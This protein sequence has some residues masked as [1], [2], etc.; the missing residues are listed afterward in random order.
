MTQITSKVISL[1]HDGRG[2]L[3]CGAKTAHVRFA[4]PGDEIEATLV[5]RVKG[6]LQGRLDRIVTPAPER[7][8]CEC[9]YG[10]S[11]GGCPLQML[12]YESQ[13]KWK[14]TFVEQAFRAAGFDFAIPEAQASDALFRHRNRMDYVISPGEDGGIALGLKEPGRWWKTLDLKTC[15]MLSDDAV[16]CLA[17]T[18]DWLKRNSVVPWDVRSHVGFARYL[19]I[20][21]G[22]NTGERLAIL[23]THGPELPDEAGLVEALSPFATTILHA[24]NP[25]ITDLS[26]GETYRLLHGRPELTEEVNGIRYAIPPRSFFQ[27]NTAGAAALSDIVRGLADLKGD[28]TLLDLYCGVGF[29]SL[30]LAKSAKRVLGVE[31]DA[32]AIGAARRNAEANGA[33]NVEFRPEKAEDLSWETEQP[34]VVL[35]DPPRSGLH[36]KVIDLLL[37]KAPPRIVYVSC[38]YNS[39]VKELPRFL[40]RYKLTKIRLLDMFPHTPHVETVVVFERM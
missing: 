38:N 1:D 4:V 25:T 24:V 36:P 33:L 3:P 2:T 8:A 19:V 10:G 32:D 39:L 22:K 29:F 12:A 26:I 27:T 11:C 13:L 30:Q 17:A 31:L 6:E 28:E 15:L 23:V 20:R 35:I 5:K 34:D 9:P 14:R 21:E 7:V 16:K 18:R 37:E 40:T